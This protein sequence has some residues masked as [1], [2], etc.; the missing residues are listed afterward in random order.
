[1]EKRG[2]KNYL[3]KH[4]GTARNSFEEN[5]L[6]ELGQQFLDNQRIKSGKLSL[7]DSRYDKNSWEELLSKLEFISALDTPTSDFFNY[8]YH[9]LGLSG[10]RQNY[11]AVK[12][13]QN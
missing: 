7:F 5:Q 13:S 8:F 2:R 6:K 11:L 1:M 3:V 10:Y 4:L 9:Q 12:Q